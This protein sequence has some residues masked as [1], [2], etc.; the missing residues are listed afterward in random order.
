MKRMIHNNM[1]SEKYV[2]NK[3]GYNSCVLIQARKRLR[4]PI[5][6]NSSLKKNIQDE[7]STWNTQIGWE[8]IVSYDNNSTRSL[9]QDRITSSKN[10]SLH[11]FLKCHYVDWEII[12][13]KT[14]SLSY[15]KWKEMFSMTVDCRSSNNTN[16]NFTLAPWFA[17][18]TSLKPEPLSCLFLL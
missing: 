13:E 18:S 1:A 17:R 9:H 6:I 2:P 12:I 16:D 10:Q 15:W 11:H 3:Q 4:K 5:F 8:G 7:K 14:I